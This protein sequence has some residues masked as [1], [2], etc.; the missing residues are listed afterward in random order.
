MAVSNNSMKVARV[1]VTAISQGLTAVGFRLAGMAS[2]WLTMAVMPRQ[3]IRVQK[4]PYGR[5]MFGDFV[6]T[7]GSRHGTSGDETDCLFHDSPHTQPVDQVSARAFAGAGLLASALP[8]I[9]AVIVR[10]TEPG[11]NAF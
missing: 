6:G 5:N 2:A 10:F 4:R 9:L 11:T 3:H 1:T 7:W 8:S